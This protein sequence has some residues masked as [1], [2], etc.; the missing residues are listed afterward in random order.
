MTVRG[1]VLAV[2]DGIAIVRGERGD[3]SVPA[4]TA[5][6]AGDLDARLPGAHPEPPEV[7]ELGDIA[8]AYDTCLREALIGGR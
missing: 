7:E 1:R 4:H 2:T 8:I 3:T 6:R 5:W